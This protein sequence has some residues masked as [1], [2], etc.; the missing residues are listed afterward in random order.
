[1]NSRTTRRASKSKSAKSPAKGLNRKKTTSQKASSSAATSARRTRVSA[2]GVAARMSPS[3]SKSISTSSRANSSKA[4]STEGTDII[5]A[6]LADHKPLKKCIKTLKNLDRDLSERKRVYHDFALLLACHAQC[7]EQ[8]LYTAMFGDKNHLT[9]ADAHE[10][11][12]EH[13]VA[14]HLVEEI[15]RL[16]DST[17]WS[18]KVKVLAEVVE[19]HLKEEEESLL[20]RYK[21]Q[22]SA[23][24]RT[25][26]GQKYIQLRDRLMS[27]IVEQMNAAPRRKAPERMA[28]M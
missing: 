25:R 23:A 13:D 26:L 11:K 14:D 20:P 24:E 6:I 15:D 5:K 28:T 19:H 3:S 16:A 21:R 1:M 12:V 9:R 10:G 18:A 7:E 27:N 17:Y 2:K 22:S 8:A 4:R